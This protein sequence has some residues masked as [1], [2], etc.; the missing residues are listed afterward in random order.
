MKI[1]RTA[2][3]R[4]KFTGSYKKM[5]AVVQYVCNLLIKKKQPTSYPLLILI[6]LLVQIVYLIENYFF[7]KTEISKQLADLFNLSFMTDVLCQALA[8]QTCDHM[9]TPLYTPKTLE[10]CKKKKA[11]FDK[12]KQR[13]LSFAFCKTQR[14]Y[15]KIR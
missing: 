4:P 8:Y 2:S 5:S 14:S 9:H 10:T 1:L 7:Q 3:R 12:E 13:V 15:E 11:L 6:S